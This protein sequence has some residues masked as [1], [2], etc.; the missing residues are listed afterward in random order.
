MSAKFFRSWSRASEAILPCASLFPPQA[1]DQS[2]AKELIFKLRR[3][4]ADVSHSPSN[5]LDADD[6]RWNDWYDAGLPAAV[7]QC[8]E[9]VIVVDRVWDSSSWMAQE[10]QVASELGRTGELRRFYWNPNE[11]MVRAAGMLP[12]L[13]SELPRDLDAAVEVLLNA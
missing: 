8:D 13:Q 3:M 4:G 5:P 9:F 11:I 10:A 1:V 7:R 6:P 12:Y 2:P